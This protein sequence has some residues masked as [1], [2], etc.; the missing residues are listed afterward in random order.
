MEIKKELK[1]YEVKMLCDEC[2]KGFMI[3]TG[4]AYMTSPPRYPHRCS[5]DYCRNEETYDVSYPRITY[6]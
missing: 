3:S 4:M 5:D 1:T 2:E 6:E